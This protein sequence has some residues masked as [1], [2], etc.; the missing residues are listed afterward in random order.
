MPRNLLF[1]KYATAHDQQAAYIGF[2]LEA[3]FTL[4]TIWN[5]Q[6]SKSAA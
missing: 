4:S 6:L 2:H 5:L 3:Y 1:L